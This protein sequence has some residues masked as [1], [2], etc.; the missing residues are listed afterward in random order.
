MQMV[1]E[2]P[3]TSPLSDISVTHIADFLV[4]LS[5]PTQPN[6]SY[7]VSYCC[8]L[9]FTTYNE[10][11]KQAENAVQSINANL[12]YRFLMALW[13]MMC[14]LGHYRVYRVTQNET[15]LAEHVQLGRLVH[16]HF[17]V[18]VWLSLHVCVCPNLLLMHNITFVVMAT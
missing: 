11:L 14:T 5:C 10:Q 9:L 18:S 2:A 6:V 7:V 13:K 12:P 4:H 17:G 16:Y 3:P 1:I 15:L 8:Y